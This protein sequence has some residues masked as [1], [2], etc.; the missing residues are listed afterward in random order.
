[1]KIDR[2]AVYA[3]A[4]QPIAQFVVDSQHRGVARVVGGA[5]VGCAR[6]LGVLVGFRLRQVQHLHRGRVIGL[7]VGDPNRESQSVPSRWVL[8]DAV[9]RAATDVL[10]DCIVTQK[11]PFSPT[12]V[13]LPETQI[14]PRLA[15]RH[16]LRQGGENGR[17]LLP[18]LVA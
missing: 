16:D 1:V 2:T 7:G 3:N 13:S 14:R 10:D 5:D 12:P 18:R 15:A 4:C 9:G 6:R 8:A 17:D 11:R